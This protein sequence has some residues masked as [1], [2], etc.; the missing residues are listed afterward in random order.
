MTLPSE[1]DLTVREVADKLGCTTKFVYNLIERGE[2]A[3][4]K[5][6]QRFIRIPPASL[7]TFRSAHTSP[8]P[9][10]QRAELLGEG[11]VQAVAE[12]AAAAPPLSEEQKDTIRAAF[13]A[14]P[15]M[16]HPAPRP[17]GAGR[18]S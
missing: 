5:Y 18:A 12:S 13:R 4:I 2:L 9:A 6:G 14:P 1:T 11:T 16:R 3:A 15:K 17:K 10:Q 7:D 8:T